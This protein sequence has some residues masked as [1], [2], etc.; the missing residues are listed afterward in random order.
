M[1]FEAERKYMQ[2]AI[3][4]AK[5]NFTM[6]A[7]GPFGAT[8]VKNGEIVAVAA[9]S[10][11][12]DDATCHAEMN[13]I[14]AASKQLGTHDLSECTIYSTTEPCPMC[15]SAIH[16][17]KIERIVY[18]TTI[19]DVAKLGFNEL[20]IS[21]DEMKSQGGSPVEIFPDFMRKECH[22]MLEEWQTLTNKQTY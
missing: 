12:E 14:R 20:S 13:A 15:F 18:G 17:A 19:S 16:W 21:N 2:L 11:L 22:A 4:R 7:G 9:N 5:N 1:T 3:D 6:M 10:V 8:I